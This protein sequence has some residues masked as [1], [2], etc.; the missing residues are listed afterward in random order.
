MTPGRRLPEAGVAALAAL[1][2]LAGCS[3]AGARGVE[4]SPA[5]TLGSSMYSLE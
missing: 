3:G 4:P 1:V 5:P 2:L